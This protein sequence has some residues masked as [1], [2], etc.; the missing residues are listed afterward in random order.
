MLRQRLRTR[1]PT[2]AL[3]GNL[4]VFILACALIFYGAILVLLACKLLSASALNSVS[5]YRSAYDYLAGLEEGDL[6]GVFRLIAAALGVLAFLLFAYLGSK[7]LPRPYLARH[8]LQLADEPR[9]VV[10]VEPR[11][12]E[13][14]AET[15]AL[16]HASICSAA[17][18]YG[19]GEL[20][21]EV[22]A[23]HASGL[24]TTLRET[25]QSVVAAIEQHGLP[26]TPI[27]IN[28]TGYERRTQRELD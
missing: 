28:L 15:A 8:D 14:I 21:L 10:S 1:R 12:I 9:G 11:A 26:S 24:A 20:T 7:Q 4:L 17:G 25:Q 19:P 5:G 18:R 2:L 6:S 22:T 3:F 23:R 16:E 27:H 13:R